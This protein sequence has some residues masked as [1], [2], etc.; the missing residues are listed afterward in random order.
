MQSR[1]SLT[2]NALFLEK[3]KNTFII[4]FYKMKK[5]RLMNVEMKIWK[6]WRL[7]LR[8]STNKGCGKVYDFIRRTRQRLCKVIDVVGKNIYCLTDFRGVE[9]NV[10]PSRIMFWPQ[11]S[12]LT[13]DRLDL[14]RSIHWTGLRIDK[15]K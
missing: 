6:K 4:K 11:G 15:M 12:Q 10:H 5:K 3:K 8:K 9:K 14:L 7:E 1:M 2:P 13:P